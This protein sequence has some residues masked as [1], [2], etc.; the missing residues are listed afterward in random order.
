MRAAC[1]AFGSVSSPRN[2][3][4]GERFMR[5]AHRSVSLLIAE[6]VPIK[7]IQEVGGHS[8]LGTTADIY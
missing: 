6:G 3:S 5:R 2:D 4:N 1:F 7:V 8:L